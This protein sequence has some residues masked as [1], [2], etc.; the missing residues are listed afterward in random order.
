[1]EHTVNYV[2]EGGISPRF[3]SPTTDGSPAQRSHKIY[4]EGEFERNI[5]ILARLV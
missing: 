5:K 3:N 4:V 2:E 1:M